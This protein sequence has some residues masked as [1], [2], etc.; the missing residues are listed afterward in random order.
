MEGSLILEKTRMTY[1]PEG[2]VL[3]INFGQPHPADDSDITDE[4]VI[5]RL[6]EGK[7]VGLSILNAM[8]RLYQT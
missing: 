6:C 1:D 3:Y 8:E 5:V 7:I 4:G 2:D